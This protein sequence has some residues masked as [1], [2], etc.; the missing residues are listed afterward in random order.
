MIT[1]LLYA[2]AAAAVVLALL[3]VGDQ[4]FGSRPL[5]RV[6]Q[7]QLPPLPGA[8]AEDVRTRVV[9]VRSR[10]A[11]ATDSSRFGVAGCLRFLLCE[12]HCVGLTH[13]EDAGD[14]TSTCR[15]CGTPRSTTTDGD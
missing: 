4:L 3:V 2:Y 14:G 6:V 9:S 15:R 1:V 11:G 12:G 13:H 8:Y 5:P 10:R 7:R